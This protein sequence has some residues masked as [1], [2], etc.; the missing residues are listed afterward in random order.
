M[1]EE[2]KNYEVR[3][4]VLNKKGYPQMNLVSS[5][6]KN[7]KYINDVDKKIRDV[8]P[9][10]SLNK[11]FKNLL[12]HAMLICD[13]NVTKVDESYL[14]QRKVHVDPKLAGYECIGFEIKGDDDEQK[15]VLF[16]R[17]KTN[18]GPVEFKTPAVH[19][20]GQK[21]KYPYAAQLSESIDD[22]VEKV[23]EYIDGVDITSDQVS[24]DFDNPQEEE[25]ENEDESEFE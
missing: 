13:I 8:L 17:K 21:A 11:S 18:L 25:E 16:V 7:G 24:L 10:S 14:V 6:S 3:K 23:Q 2:N 1:S 22:A 20:H 5:T 19:T 12:P 15:I 4:A 9:H